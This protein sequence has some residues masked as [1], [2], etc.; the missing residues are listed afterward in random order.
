M[1]VSL[2]GFVFGLLITVGCYV[3]VVFVLISLTCFLF[4]DLEF[5]FSVCGLLFC[6]AL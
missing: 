5:V 2:S 6:C 1:I 3:L 4:D